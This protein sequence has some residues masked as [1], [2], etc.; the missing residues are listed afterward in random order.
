[1]RERGHPAD[2]RLRSS[3]HRQRV[4]EPWRRSHVRAARSTVVEA[5]SAAGS[6]STKVHD[7]VR[8]GGRPAAS[9][10]S[11]TWRRWPPGTAQGQPGPRRGRAPRG[12]FR[13][14]R[15]A[16]GRQFVDEP[17]TS[18]R[19]SGRGTNGLRG[20]SS[21]SLLRS[22]TLTIVLCR[23]QPKGLLAPSPVEAFCGGSGWQPRRGVRSPAGRWGNGSGSSAT[24]L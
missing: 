14:R 6:T 17:G 16:P 13:C 21:C 12:R 9:A 8:M 23:G 2:R 1:V 10:A 20:R 22:R 4:A 5:T 24:W 19:W 18:A 15:G 11:N 3:P 7:P